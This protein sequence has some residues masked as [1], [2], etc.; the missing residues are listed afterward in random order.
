MR[1]EIGRQGGRITA[2]LG[3]TQGR[4]LSVCLQAAC[5]LPAVYRVVFS[6]S[7]VSPLS[8]VSLPAGSAGGPC[9]QVV[10]IY[11]GSRLSPGVVYLSVYRSICEL[12][13]WR[14]LS[15]SR[16]SLSAAS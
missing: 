9:L 10:W 13:L 14:A 3:H 2:F 15:C 12:A 4:V 7:V 11:P 1:V 16:A 6:L 8:A 5:G